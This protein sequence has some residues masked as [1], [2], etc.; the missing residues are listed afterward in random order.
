MIERADICEDA[1]DET[2]RETLRATIDE[3][4][5]FILLPW[6]MPEALLLRV[7]EVLRHDPRYERIP[8]LIGE[9]AD[10][11]VLHTAT[12]LIRE[13]GFGRRA[14]DKGIASVGVA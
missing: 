8:V 3:N 5:G 1:T 9:P 12:W 11:E 10:A 14:A 6:S 2:I 13:A 7:L 4:T